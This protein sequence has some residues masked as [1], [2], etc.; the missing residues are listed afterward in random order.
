M[1]IRRHGKFLLAT[2][3]ASTGVLGSAILATPAQGITG[4][5]S[6]SVL[7]LSAVPPAAQLQPNLVPGSP[8]MQ[9]GTADQLRVWSM[10][11]NTGVATYVGVETPAQVNATAEA[12]G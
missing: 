4:S 3:I 7:P 1:K 12:S 6:L 9:A 5:G 11:V 8:P 10:N 2:A